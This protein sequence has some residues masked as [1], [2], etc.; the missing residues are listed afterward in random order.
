MNKNV[1]N[2]KTCLL[3]E[4]L[5]EMLVGE[6]K[7]SMREFGSEMADIMGNSKNVSKKNNLNLYL[8]VFRVFK[9]NSNVIF[10]NYITYSLLLLPCLMTYLVHRNEHNHVFRDWGRYLVVVDKELNSNMFKFLSNRQITEY[11]LEFNDHDRHGA[12]FKIVNHS[13]Q[14]LNFLFNEINQLIYTSADYNKMSCLIDLAYK[15]S[16]WDFMGEILS[17]LPEYQPNRVDSVSDVE[18]NFNIINNC[19]F[20]VGNLTS[21]IETIKKKIK[22]ML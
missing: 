10:Y 7:K 8:V 17:Q 6:K 12:L 16:Y 19:V 20:A 13:G 15:K 9:N 2:G 21:F 3:H 5:C 18:V 14:D 11:P 22:N 1:L 4:L